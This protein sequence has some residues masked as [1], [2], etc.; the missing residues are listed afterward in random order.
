MVARLHRASPGG[1]LYIRQ[2]SAVTQVDSLKTG[3]GIRVHLALACRQMDSRSRPFSL[4]RGY[5]PKK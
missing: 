1:Q 2:T 3:Q 4:A 5:G